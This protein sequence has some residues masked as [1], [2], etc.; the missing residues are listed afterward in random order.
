MQSWGE[1][2]L[3]LPP[4]FARWAGAPRFAR[5]ALCSRWR[6]GG[7]V[8]SGVWFAFGVRSGYLHLFGSVPR[9]VVDVVGLAQLTALGALVEVGRRVG[10]QHRVVVVRDGADLLPVVA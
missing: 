4:R 8:P 1:A 10:S 2:P 3:F 7:R 5:F 6:V 9:V